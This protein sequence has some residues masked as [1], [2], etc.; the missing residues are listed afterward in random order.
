MIRYDTNDTSLVLPLWESDYMEMIPPESDLNDIFLE[1]LVVGY[2]KMVENDLKST[3]NDKEEIQH[4]FIRNVLSKYLSDRYVIISKTE[5]MGINEECTIPI[6]AGTGKKMDITV[7]DSKYDK[8]VLCI[9]CKFPLSSYKKNMPNYEDILF[10]ESYRL[11]KAN[12]NLPIFSF[13]VMMSNIPVF[14][15]DKEITGF[16]SITQETLDTYDELAKGL[17]VEDKFLKGFGLMVIDDIVVNENMFRIKNLEQFK[18]SHQNQFSLDLFLIK[19]YH[20]MIYN[21]FDKFINQILDCIKEYEKT[22]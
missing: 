14:N 10:G 2:R 16:D 22:H 17:V 13:N 19:E 11:H 4:D 8:V 18:Q 5:G 6:F 21:D 20:K 3:G 1:N 12:P 9:N 15:G 7:I